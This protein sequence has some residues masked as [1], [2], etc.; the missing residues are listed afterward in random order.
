MVLA[1]STVLRTAAQ[2]LAR[3]VA[4]AS[5]RS[6]GR[7]QPWQRISQSVSR[8]AYSSS[9]GGSGHTQAKSDLPWLIGSVALG[10]PG[11]W[12]ML[13]PGEAHHDAHHEKHEEKHEEPK[14]EAPKEEPKEEPKKE[15]P[16]EEP[17]VEAK[18]ESKEESK[19][20][21]KEQPKEEAPKEDSSEDKNTRSSQDDA[22]EG[23]SKKRIDSDNRKE[24]GSGDSKA[25]AEG[26]AKDKP[27]PSKEPLSQNQTSGKQ[28]GVSNTDTRHST[29]VDND[30]SKSKKSEGGVDTA[31]SK[32]T[33]S[34]NRPADEEN[35]KSESS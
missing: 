11:T 24:I 1:R 17:K 34:P 26:S 14:E 33:I 20:E 16:K 31:K 7:Q 32:G 2:Q 18:E 21:S 15:E 3:P 9:H 30:P 29:D 25:D 13:Q 22:K 19:D 23:A 27:A 28:Q 5:F 6:A 35:E 12:W 8:R 4:R 10:V